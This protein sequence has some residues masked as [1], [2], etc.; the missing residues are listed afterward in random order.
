MRKKFLIILPLFLIILFGFLNLKA[1][2]TFRSND[3]TVKSGETITITV[4]S[5]EELENYDI[6]L[7][8]YTGLTYVSCSADNAA[9]NSSAGKISFATLGNKVTTLG[10]FTFKAPQVTQTTKYTVEF[11]IDNGTTSTTNKST[12]TVNPVETTTTG[13]DTNTTTNTTTGETTTNTTT[14]T[15]T[16]TPTTET[17]KGS[18]SSFYINGIKVNEYLTITNKDSVSIKL[19]TSTKEGATIYNSLTKKT[20]TVKSGETTNIQILEGTNTLTITLDTGA[21]GTRKI[22][23][24]KEEEVKANVIEN[25]EE[26]EEEIKTEL[27]SLLIKGVISEE[28]KMDLSFTPEFLSDVFEY[29][30]NLDE[31]LSDITKLDIEA[32]A[33]Q[34]DCKVEIAGNENLQEGENIITITLTS[35]DGETIVTYKIIVTKEAKVVEISAPV[36]EVEQEVVKPIWNKTQTILITIFTSIIAL[37]GIMYAVIEYR[38][39]KDNEEEIKIPF[40]ENTFEDYRTEQEDKIEEIRT[41]EDIANEKVKGKS[42]PKKGKHF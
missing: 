18:I 12:V 20:Y 17:T 6:S 42:K 1:E 2:A 35:K 37:M 16:T 36:V 9:V 7:K 3:P 4:K 33:S 41:R 27:K 22:Y 11:S 39:K 29:Q 38:Y 31:N 10:T 14:N 19:N 32:I 40:S 25:T 26:P 15:T 5:T 23:S 24:Q 8:S 30:I 34:D 21:K 28:E 13:K